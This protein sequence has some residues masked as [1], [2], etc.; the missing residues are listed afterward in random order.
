[1]SREEFKIETQLVQG[2]GE[3]TEGQPR[4]YPIYQTTTYDYNSPEVLAELFDLKRDGYMYSR[5]GN[6][7]VTAFEEKIAQLEKGV[8]ALAL[9]SGQAANVTAILNICGCG[10]HIVSLATIYG[11][12][13]NLFK[14]TLKK[15]GNCYFCFSRGFRRGDKSSFSREYKGAFWRNFGKSRDECN[16]F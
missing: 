3:F 14:S 15:Y 4:V 7:T 16:R 1:M 5:I 12:T 2:S 11:G 9:A 6:P 8:G 13:A 10:D